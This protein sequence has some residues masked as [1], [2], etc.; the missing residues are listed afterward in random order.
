MTRRQ[1]AQANR[2]TWTLAALCLL[3]VAV[4]GWALL[5]PDPSPSGPVPTVAGVSTCPLATL[6][7]QVADTVRLIQSDGPFPFPRND[8]VVFGN[9]EGHLPDQTRGY[10]HE[11]T[12]ITP[13]AS[14]RSTRRIITGGSPST[15]PPQYYYTGDHYDSFCLV[16]DVRRRG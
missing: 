6:P 10:Y 15:D 9:R 14:N 5:R 8:G 12:V 3:I 13:G 2:C 7:P 1:I 11:Y 4:G 16:A